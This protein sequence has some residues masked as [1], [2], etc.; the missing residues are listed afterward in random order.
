[1]IRR[2]FQLENYVLRYFDILTVISKMGHSMFK[3]GNQSCGGITTLPSEDEIVCWHR[4]LI[5][6]TMVAWCPQPGMAGL[7]I[8]RLQVEPHLKSHRVRSDLRPAGFSFLP[9]WDVCGL[10]TRWKPHVRQDIIGPCFLWGR[11]GR[12]VGGVSRSRMWNFSK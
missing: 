12:R 10:K 9:C 5:S 7:V 4:F 1:M 3:V 6:L 11:R 2:K 8:I